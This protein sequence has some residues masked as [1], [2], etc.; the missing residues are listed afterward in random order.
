VWAN[1]LSTALKLTILGL[2]VVLGIF[3]LD[4]DNFNVAAS[5]SVR[6]FDHAFML[7]FFMFPGF[8]FLPVQVSSIHNSKKNLPK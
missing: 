6:N 5:S 8:S 2:F 4:L 7:I 1:D 3:Y